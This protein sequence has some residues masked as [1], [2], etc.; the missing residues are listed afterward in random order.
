MA[1]STRDQEQPRTAQAADAERMREAARAA[2]DA[3]EHP[4]TE[5]VEGG[6]Y[7]VGDTLVDADGKA[8]KDQG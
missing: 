5:T 4:P 7:R 6:R 2:A 8:L 3:Q 1:E